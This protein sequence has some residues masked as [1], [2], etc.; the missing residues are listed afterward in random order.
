MGLTGLEDKREREREEKG[1][2]RKR[3]SEDEGGCRRRDKAKCRKHRL[4]R[5]KR[6]GVYSTV[7]VCLFILFVF[8]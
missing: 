3:D 8:V 2:R 6:E 5:E 7:S 4:L 1:N